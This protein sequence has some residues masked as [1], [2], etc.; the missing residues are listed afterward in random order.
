MCTFNKIKGRHPHHLDNFF[1]VALTLCPTAGSDCSWNWSCNAGNANSG[2]SSPVWHSSLFSFETLRT[3]WYPVRF[4]VYTAAS[5]RV[6]PFWYIGPGS[7]V[8]VDRRFRGIL[9][10]EAVPTPETAVPSMRLHGAIPQK[11]VVFKLIP[12]IHTKSTSQFH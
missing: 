4:Q 1:I 3:K 6:T 9:M 7:M 10:M 8:E 12:I 2:A 11:A 5:I